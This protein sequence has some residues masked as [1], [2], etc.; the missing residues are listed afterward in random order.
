ME[1]EKEHAN[2]VAVNVECR[3]SV[4][5]F[6]CDGCLIHSPLA[7][8]VFCIQSGDGVNL[9]TQLLSTDQEVISIRKSIDA[10]AQDIVASDEL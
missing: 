6:C 3:E 7:L 10:H 4:P 8:W 2:E 5:I 1:G 9:G